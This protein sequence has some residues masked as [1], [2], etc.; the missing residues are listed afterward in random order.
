MRG[1]HLLG[2]LQ[3]IVHLLVRGIRGCGV[4]EV[5]KAIFDILRICDST[6]PKIFVSLKKEKVCVGTVFTELF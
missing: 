4:G 6:M 2:H 1:W 3:W 5:D